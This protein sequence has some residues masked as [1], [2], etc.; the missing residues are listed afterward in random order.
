[1]QQALASAAA[2]LIALSQMVMWY[3]CCTTLACALVAVVPISP[4]QPLQLTLA[5]AAGKAIASR[6]LALLTVG[7][8]WP[9]RCC[10]AFANPTRP[11]LQTPQNVSTVPRQLAVA[12]RMW[13]GPWAA[14]RLPWQQTTAVSARCPDLPLPGQKLVLRLPS[15]QQSMLVP[16]Q[17]P[18]A[19]SMSA[20]RHVH[21]QFVAVYGLLGTHPG[22]FEIEPLDV[23]H[24]QVA[25]RQP[26][27][28]T[29]PRAMSR[30]QHQTT[31]PSPRLPRRHAGR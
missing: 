1:M 26:I 10:P 8:V 28:G 25:M 21:C 27:V 9:L 13:F 18:P 7:L 4:S 31:S 15:A 22:H 12:V 5:R 19:K 24:L 11:P 2:E 16:H 14:A 20:V 17:A 29:S 30:A 3:P 6:A 23:S